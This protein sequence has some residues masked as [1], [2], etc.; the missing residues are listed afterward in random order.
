MSENRVIGRD[1]RLPWHLPADLKRFKE[2]TT[3]HTVIMGRK[4]FDSIGKPLPKRRSIIVTRTPKLRVPGAE[5]VHSLDE[6]V[7]MAK[8]EDEVFIIGGGEIFAEALYAADRIYLTLV[9]AKI[10]GDTFFPSLDA[11]EWTL[12]EEDRYAADANN[13]YSMSFQR[14]ERMRF[15][16]GEGPI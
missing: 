16:S 1:G 9:H 13:Q 4:T 6:A 3:S 8:G 7:A 2:L 5:V 15:A 12:L 11:D 10:E 14:Y